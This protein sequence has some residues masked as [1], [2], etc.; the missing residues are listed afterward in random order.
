[1]KGIYIDYSFVLIIHN[2]KEKFMI[3]IIDSLI[4]IR[5][6]IYKLNLFW[7]FIHQNNEG[8]CDDTLH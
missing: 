4:K 2:S 5:L 7:L 3:K 8:F 6:E 1:M